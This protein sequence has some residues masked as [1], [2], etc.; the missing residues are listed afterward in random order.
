LKYRKPENRSSLLVLQKDTLGK[1]EIRG[2]LSD[3]RAQI[4]GLSEKENRRL[5]KEAEERSDTH[6]FSADAPDDTYTTGC[7]RRPMAGPPVV[8]PRAAAASTAAAGC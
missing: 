1:G 5:G 6:L 8:D 7:P 3:N 2:V 4:S